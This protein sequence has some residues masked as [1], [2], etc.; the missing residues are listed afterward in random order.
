MFISAYFFSIYLAI[1]AISIRF[2]RTFEWNCVDMDWCCTGKY[3]VDIVYLI[4]CVGFPIYNLED[5]NFYIFYW[6][7]L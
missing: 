7:N 4:T 3:D 6:L 2:D 5:L 1:R